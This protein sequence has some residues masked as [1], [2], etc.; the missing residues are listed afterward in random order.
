MRDLIRLIKEALEAYICRAKADTEYS[1]FIN[2]RNEEM[3]KKIESSAVGSMEEAMQQKIISMP[4][5]GKGNKR[6]H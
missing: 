4:I 1:I 5:L 6:E 2:A 3:L